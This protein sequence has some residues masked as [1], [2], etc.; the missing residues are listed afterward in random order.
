MSKSLDIQQ[1]L[2]ATSYLELPS[3]RIISSPFFEKPLRSYGIVAYCEETEKWLLVQRQHTPEFIITLRGSYRL[4]DIPRL[5]AGYSS[6]EFEKIQSLLRSLS[7]ETPPGCGMFP[8]LFQATI[9]NNERDLI[10]GATRFL[11]V[12]PIFRIECQKWIH[13]DSRPEWLW[14]KGRMH[15]TV[16]KP[17]YPHR[18]NHSPS[19]QVISDRQKKETPFR[20]ALREFSEETG[21]IIHDCIN[22]SELELSHK[23]S[24]KDSPRLV[25]TTPLTESFRGSNGRIYET[26]CWVCVFS[27]SI[28]PP[29]IPDQNVPGEIGDCKWVTEE[30]AGILLSNSKYTML[31]EAHELIKGTTI[32]PQKMDP[33]NYNPGSTSD[34]AVLDQPPKYHQRHVNPPETPKY[35]SPGS[36][37]ANRTNRRN[38]DLKEDIFDPSIIDNW[39][40]VT[41]RRH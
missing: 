3:R 13:R 24:T 39:Q 4:S 12:V 8:S 16:S 2:C 36:K 40:V 14:P 17:T 11:E 34:L 15:S 20:C 26:T 1:V 21:I 32:S 22:P 38:S 19:G 10:Y 23:A 33:S 25:S 18:N 28:E 5:V 29:P 31:R 27:R 30:E 7:V 6:L 35:R 37:I 9:S 41:R